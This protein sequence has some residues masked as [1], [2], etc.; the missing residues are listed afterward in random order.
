MY[1]LKDFWSRVAC[2][3]KKG[4]LF[5]VIYALK[6]FQSRVACAFI[7]LIIKGIGIYM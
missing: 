1:S 4:W 3:F 7:Q 5:Y 2:G 6:D